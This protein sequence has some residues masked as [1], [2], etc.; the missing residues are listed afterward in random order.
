VK[1]VEFQKKMP[2][3]SSFH[4]KIKSACAEIELAIRWHSPMIIPVLYTTSHVFTD[5]IK[6]IEEELGAFEQVLAPIEL[7]SR[8]K[9][10]V[11]PVQLNQTPNTIFSVSGF[12]EAG[13]EDQADAYRFLNLH[14]EYF[15]EKNTRLFLWLKPEEFQKMT[16]YAP[17]FWAFRH[18]ILDFTKNRAT[19]KRSAKFEGLALDRFPWQVPAINI[20]DALAYRRK[21]LSILPKNDEALIMRLDLC[22]QIAGLNFQKN[23]LA[24][25]K[26][27]LSDALQLF[28]N[29]LLDPLKAKFLWALV[30]ISIK[31]GLIAEAESLVQEAIDLAEPE[32]FSSI[33]LAELQ[34][35]AGRNAN[36]LNI[37]LK[38]LEQI[39]EDA[40]GWNEVGNIYANLGRFD[41]SIAAYEK[42]FSYLGDP[43]I[44]INQAML[45]RS[46]GKDAESNA[47]LQEISCEDLRNISRRENSLLNELEEELC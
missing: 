44:Q 3:Q 22:G 17:D 1:K 16:L 32:V 13:G 8:Q 12:D 33:T 36:A 40:I 4:Q 45:L 24:D 46:V 31:E 41:E 11:E 43:K 35:K 29:E 47:M 37:A 6:L 39:P 5:A 23:S 25:A 38:A 7:S 10:L 2:R 34:R 30:T 21:E 26:Q 20:E 28:P 14:R 15:I 19:P 9:N 18:F 42:A 27:I